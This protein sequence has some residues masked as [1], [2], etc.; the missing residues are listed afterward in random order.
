MSM[1]AP[2][3]QWFTCSRVVAKPRV[4]LLCFPYAGGSANIYHQWSKLLAPDIE[5]RA[6]QLPGRTFR[7][8]EPSITRMDALISALLPQIEP[9][10]DAPLALFG[11]SMGSLIAYELAA[12]LPIPP[13]LFFPSARGAAHV[14]HGP[15]IHQLPHDA[16]VHEV[17]R[18]YGPSEVMHHAEMASLV[19]PPLRADF[20]L[21]ETYVHRDRPKLSM[22]IVALA[23][24]ADHIAPPSLVRTWEE[25]AGASFSMHEVVGNHFFVDAE[26]TTVTQIID[27]ALT[28]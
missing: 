25:L 10:L 13:A 1:V 7:L 26:R 6:L 12:A 11:H 24:T 23:G 28:T 15:A 4:R 18:R 22:P 2:A 20:E 17:E 27:K 5:V 9:L 14:A 3:S 16:F 21:L 19:I 8:R